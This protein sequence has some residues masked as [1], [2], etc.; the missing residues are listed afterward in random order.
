MMRRRATGA[1]ACCCSSAGGRPSTTSRASPRSRWRGRS[2]PTRY[3]VVPVAITTDG[4]VAARR[5]GPGAR[6]RRARRAARRVRR[7]RRA[8]PAGRAAARPRL[9]GGSR[10]IRRRPAGGRVDVVLPAAPRPVRRGRHGAG[11]ARARRPALRRLRACSA[12]RSAMD[13]V[14][15]KRAFAA[16]R[17]AARRGTSRSATAHD[18]DAF[19]DAVEAELGLPVLRE[20]GEH[21]LVGRGVEG[22]RPRPSSRRRSTSRFEFDEWIL[23]GGG[24]RRPRDR[25]RRC[26]ATTRPRRRCPARSCPA[27]EF[28]SY[29]DKY[30]DGDGRAARARAARPTSRPPRCARSRCAAFEALPL[31][32]DGAGRLLPRGRRAG[33]PRQRGQH[34]PGLHADLDVPAALGGDR[35]CPTPSCST[36]SSTS[37]SNATTRR[38][39]RAGRQRETSVRG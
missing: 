33:L 5:R 27:A 19:V 8:R 3:E 20:A 31:R 14:M 10:R 16:A 21:G 38:A 23:V 17:P 25:G 26:S 15:M 22:A 32:G 13:K 24:D 9:V 6:S 11:P 18:R 28:Y 29:A 30:E 37:P 2:T 12:R 34:D 39:E 4:P 36:A 7:R 1:C 35:A